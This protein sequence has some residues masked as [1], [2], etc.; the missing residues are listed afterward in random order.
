MDVASSHNF[1]KKLLEMNKSQ[2]ARAEPTATEQREAQSVHSALM[3]RW[4]ATYTTSKSVLLFLRRFLFL[5]DI[6]TPAPIAS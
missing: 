5:P 6:L 3:R 1:L 2:I 4:R